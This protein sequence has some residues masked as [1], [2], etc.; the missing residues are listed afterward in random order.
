MA[1]N[2]ACLKDTTQL[3]STERHPNALVNR[4]GILVLRA[5]SLKS[6]LWLLALTSLVLHFVGHL[7]H[8]CV[9][10]LTLKATKSTSGHGAA[11]VTCEK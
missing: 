4:S 8:S 5:I 10:L 11:V 6:S 7:L 3:L 2:R 9:L 1:V